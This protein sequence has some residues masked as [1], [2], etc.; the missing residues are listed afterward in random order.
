M[1]QV[2]KLRDNVPEFE[3]FRQRNEVL[4]ELV[5]NALLFFSRQVFTLTG[6]LDQPLDPILIMREAS[7][8]GKT[9]QSD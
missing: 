1:R 5:H 3:A 8:L 7:L 9:F 4:L 2:L 6:D